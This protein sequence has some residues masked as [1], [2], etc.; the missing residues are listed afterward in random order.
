MFSDDRLSIA[1]CANCGFFF[2]KDDLVCGLCK[3]CRME[4]TQKT[5]K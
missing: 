4:Q 1:Q 3:T 2:K 5:I